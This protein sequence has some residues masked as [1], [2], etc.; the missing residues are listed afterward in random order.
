[1]PPKVDPKKALAPPKNAP[2]KNAP[3]KKD[4]KKPGKGTYSYFLIL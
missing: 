1:M 2:S 3:P 4:T